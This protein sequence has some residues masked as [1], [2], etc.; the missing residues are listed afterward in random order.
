MSIPQ[1]GDRAFLAHPGEHRLDLT[2]QPRGI[3]TNQE[4]GANVN[5]NGALCVLS[6]RQARNSEEGGLF[7][8]ATRV[9]NHDGRMALETKELQIRQRSRELHMP[10]CEAKLHHSLASTRVNRKD[11]G[12][13]SSNPFQRGKKPREHLPLVDVGWTVQRHQYERFRTRPVLESERPQLLLAIG[14]WQK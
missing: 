11:N 9:G 7:L 4:I 10:V 12:H 14:C 2:L 5:G 3:A 1:F 6:H 8:D 13:L